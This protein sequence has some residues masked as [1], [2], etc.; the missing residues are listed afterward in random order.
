MITIGSYAYFFFHLLIMCCLL[1]LNLII[2]DFCRMILTR[3]SQNWRR[4]FKI[5]R[6]APVW[7][8]L[9]FLFMVHC[10]LNCR[11][12][13][14]LAL[15][16]SSQQRNFAIILQDKYHTFFYLIA[17]PS[18][19]FGFLFPPVKHFSCYAAFLILYTS[20]TG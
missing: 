15:V 20:H 12:V 5:L 16:C 13:P 17:L 3:W 10:H 8:L 14:S 7:M 19:I 4:E 18:F 6:K 9:S 2:W 1:M 11:Q